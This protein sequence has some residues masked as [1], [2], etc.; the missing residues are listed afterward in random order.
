MRLPFFKVYRAFHELDYLP[1]AEC[2]RVVRLARAKKSAWLEGAPWLLAALA[3]I[4]W[5]LLWLWLLAEFGPARVARYVPI[6]TEDEIN[7]ILLGTTT[8][9]FAAV[10]RF[11]ARDLLLWTA[12]RD[13]IDQA[14]CPKCEQSL[15]GVRI[16]YV[17]LDV[18]MP[19]KSFVRCPEC[20]RNHNLL[21]L[22][23]TPRDLIP[24]ELR[25]MRPDVGQIRYPGFSRASW[26]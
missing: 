21:E 6:S 4:A 20:G 22:G 26:S 19:G 11:A 25:E 1:D 15:L 2:E 16:Q 7:V 12:L 9:F 13:E 5:P 10:V 3:I 18:G 8:I 17:G 23:L 14:K 24:Y